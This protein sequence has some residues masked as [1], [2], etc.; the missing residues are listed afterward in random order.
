VRSHIQRRVLVCGGAGFIGS[1]ITATL[2][3]AGHD[4]VVL[5]GMVQG[6]GGRR[7]NL[8]SVSSRVQ[9]VTMRIEDVASLDD[10][11]A[12]VDVVVDCMG[13]TRH[14]D[15]ARDPFRDLELNLA[16]HLY[17]LRAMNR[18]PYPRVI[19]LGSRHEYGDSSRRID[20]T[21]PLVPLDVQSVHKV[22]ADH[23][24]RVAARE[25][26]CGVN[27]LRFGNTFGPNQPTRGQ[28]I[29]LV[30]GLIRDLLET[31]TTTVFEG[32]RRRSCVYVDDLARIVA[33]CVD[34]ELPG[35]TAFNVPGTDVTVLQ[36]ARA[37]VRVLGH[38]KLRREP[39]PEEVRSG[40][41]GAQR[42]VASRLEGV[43]GPPP[44]TD[45]ASALTETVA[46]F[47]REL[48]AR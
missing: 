5:D 41:V 19:Y 17:L 40:E 15:A 9:L 30:G 28:D 27:S 21:T 43:I 4:V 32:G 45:L 6:T 16:S 24:F 44:I 13:W 35:Y 39:L 14:R 20:E 33:R 3:E 36:L 34:L 31:G 8:A 47:R 46:Y 48:A 25:R 38:G 26:G 29:G 1:H 10:L 22:A 23:H 18:S 42:F 7:E 37:I 2:C 11:A 12:T